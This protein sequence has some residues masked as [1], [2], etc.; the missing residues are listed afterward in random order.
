MKV[1]F[2]R[3]HSR[4]VSSKVSHEPKFYMQQ[5]K[6]GYQETYV[7]VVLS[8]LGIWKSQEAFKI[9]RLVEIILVIFFIFVSQLWELLGSSP[10]K[11]VK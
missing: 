7:A 8:T 6:K 3:S 2:R 5:L 1:Y 10:L 11:I 9:V 4:H